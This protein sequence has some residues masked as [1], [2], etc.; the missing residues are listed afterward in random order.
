M[1]ITCQNADMMTTS[2][3]CRATFGV[4]FLKKTIGIEN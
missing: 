1:V 3:A 4:L 2:K